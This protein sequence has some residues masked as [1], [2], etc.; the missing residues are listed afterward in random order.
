MEN[1]LQHR[2]SIRVIHLNDLKSAAS[3]TLVNRNLT[4]WSFRFL[5][6]ASENECADVMGGAD[7]QRAVQWEFTHDAV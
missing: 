2:A 5:L 7:L 4:E 3:F 1:A 6:T